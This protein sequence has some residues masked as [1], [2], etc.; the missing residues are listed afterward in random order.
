MCQPPFQLPLNISRTLLHRTRRMSNRLLLATLSASISARRPFA[1]QTASDQQQAPTSTTDRQNGI[2]FQL[3]A[4]QQ[5]IQNAARHFARTE[6]LPAAAELD[7]SGAFP[8]ALVERAWQLGL[9]NVHVPAAY[10]GLG[11]D[12][13]TGALIAEEFAFGCAGIETAM[14]VSEIG[15]SFNIVLVR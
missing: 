6:M 10:G 5:H 1:S 13:F 11:L 12:C 7:R 3:S 8:S 4:D 2:S 14:K 9:L 15:V